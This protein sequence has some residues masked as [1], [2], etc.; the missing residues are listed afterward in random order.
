MVDDVD[1]KVRRYLLK[2]LSRR[3]QRVLDQTAY[4]EALSRLDDR[5]VGEDILE[6]LRDA[7]S[8]T[9]SIAPSQRWTDPAEVARRVAFAKALYASRRISLHEYVIFAISP[10]EFLH[11]E[12]WIEGHYDDE[13]KPISQTI[14]KIEKEHGL[15]PD[16][17][18][19]RGQGPKEHISLNRQ[20]EASIEEKFVEMLREFGLDDLADLKEQSPKEFELLRERGRRSVFHKDEYIPAIKDVVIQYEKEAHDSSTVGAYSAAVTSLGAGV[21]GL[22]LLRCLRSPHKASRISKALPKRLRPRAP[23]DSSTWSF[24]TLVEVCLAAGWLPSIETE[25]ARYDTA[26]LAHVLRLMRN[27]VHPGKRARERPWSQT[28]EQEYRD[29][30]AIYSVLISTLGHIRRRRPRTKPL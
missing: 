21:E 11:D 24:E 23:D 20:Y 16:E 4:L 5:V 3:Q 1:P 8:S 28:D 18:W 12:R 6:Q 9:R 22:L 17:Y 26:A 10:V 15:G 2:P 13:L 19:L 29:A 27:Y 25:I 30:E 7:V 14:E